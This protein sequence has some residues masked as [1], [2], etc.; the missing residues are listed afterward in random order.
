ML[1]DPDEL[2]ALGTWNFPTQD[3]SGQALRLG[4]LGYIYTISA[5]SQHPQEAFEFIKFLTQPGPSADELYTIGAVSAR[6]DT[7]HTAPYNTLPYI[8]STEGQLATGKFFASHNGIDKWETYI[9]PRRRRR[10]SKSTISTKGPSWISMSMCASRSC[11]IS[12]LKNGHGRNKRRRCGSALAQGTSTEGAPRSS[13]WAT[14]RE[15]GRGRFQPC[16]GGSTP[17]I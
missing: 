10:G 1:A 6:N 8:V 3:G 11:G 14:P 15:I 7:R 13:P 12:N 9:G 5:S 4:R 16:Q 17:S 2:S